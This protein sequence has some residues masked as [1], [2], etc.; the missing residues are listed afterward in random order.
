VPIA[1]PRRRLRGHRRPSRQCRLVRLSRRSAS[2][3]RLC[4]D[5]RRT[6]RR[7]APVRATNNGRWLRS[8]GREVTGVTS[9]GGSGADGTPATPD[10]PVAEQA[11]RVILRFMAAGAVAWGGLVP[12]QDAALIDEDAGSLTRL[13]VELEPLTGRTG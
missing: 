5:I 1:S 9:A 12:E 10:S 8:S 7:L 11:G 2:R 6:P 13:L 3:R 4:R